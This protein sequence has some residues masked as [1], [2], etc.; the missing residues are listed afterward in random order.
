MAVRGASCAAGAAHPLP[1]PT[2]FSEPAPGPLFGSAERAPQ[3]RHASRFYEYYACPLERD[4]LLTAR[5]TVVGLV[6]DSRHA[7]SN[8]WRP[9]RLSPRALRSVRPPRT[10]WCG[11]PLDAGCP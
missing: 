8:L 9:G 7:R 1:S 6:D 5:F 2:A 10:P 11:L 3:H 4:W